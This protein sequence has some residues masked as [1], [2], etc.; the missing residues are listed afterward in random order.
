MHGIKLHLQSSLNW[1][2]FVLCGLSEFRSRCAEGAASKVDFGLKAAGEPQQLE[3][4]TADEAVVK[5]EQQAAL[6]KGG[7]YC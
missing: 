2:I 1:L 7:G 3:L 4:Q 5:V 6:T